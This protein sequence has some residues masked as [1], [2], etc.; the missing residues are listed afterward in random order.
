MSAH[1]KP[2]KRELREQRRA[3][4]LAAEQAAAAAG[5]RRRR[6]IMLLAAVGLTVVVVAVAAIATSSNSSSSPGGTTAK[7]KEA[8]ATSMFAGIPEHGGVLGDPSAPLV[9]TEYLDPQCP[10]CAEVSHDTLP[11]LLRDYVRTG[12]V[13]LQARLLHFI[14]PDSVRAA[15]FAVGAQRQDKLWPFIEAFYAV[16]G[17]ENS[18]YVTNGFLDSVAGAAS[19]DTAAARQVADSAASQDVLNTANADAQQMG[20]EGTPTFTVARGDGSAHVIAGGAHDIDSLSAALD[21]QLAK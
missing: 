11:A 16:Q 7:A 18:G 4:R 12:K 13:R 20:V 10:V 9:V 3:E 5:T 6:T 21:Q 8:A 14:G 2:T 1:V 15:R 17:A 19:V